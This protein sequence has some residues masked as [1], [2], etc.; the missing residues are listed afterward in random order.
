[1]I[2]SFMSTDGKQTVNDLADFI[3]NSLNDALRRVPGISDTQLF[4]SRYAMRIWLDPDKLAKYQLIVS[5][6]TDAIEDQNSQVSAGQLGDLPQRQGQQLNASV[7]A[8]SSLQT[9]EQFE[10]IILKSESD[11]A[12]V[13]LRDVATR[14]TGC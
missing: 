9:K 2:V 12:V 4:G 14:R 6:V 13:Q 10:A 11:G 5:D 3:D 8:G 1:M 7:T